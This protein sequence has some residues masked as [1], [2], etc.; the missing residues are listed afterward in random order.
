MTLTSAPNIFQFDQ[1]HIKN[2]F[3]YSM[4]KKALE[5]KKNLYIADNFICNIKYHGNK[6]MK[7]VFQK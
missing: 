1:K 2:Y 5:K 4:L 3:L 7:K 6:E